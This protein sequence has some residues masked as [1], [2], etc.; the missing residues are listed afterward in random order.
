ML[1]RNSGRV[2]GRG[3][4][5]EGSKVTHPSLEEVREVLTWTQHGK[6]FQERH[7]ERAR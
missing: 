7:R 1:D 6:L 3:D 2:Q 5:P 4:T